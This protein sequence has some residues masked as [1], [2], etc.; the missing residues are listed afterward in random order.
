MKVVLGER[1]HDYIVDGVEKNSFWMEASRINCGLK[2]SQ[3]VMDRGD[4]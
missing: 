4:L 2:T 1:R 3:G